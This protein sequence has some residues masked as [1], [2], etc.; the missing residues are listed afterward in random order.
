VRPD[1][2]IDVVELLMKQRP[3]RHLPVVE[4]RHLVGIVS[5]RDLLEGSTPPP[6]TAKDAMTRCPRTVAPT[7]PAAEAGSILLSE[8]FGCLPVV[9]DGVLVG[10][11]TE[12]DYMEWLADQCRP[13]RAA[14]INAV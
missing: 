8:Q 3:C 4:D 10:I 14:G 5:E 1:E 6:A 11:V 12:V 13:R 2:R 9:R 7:L